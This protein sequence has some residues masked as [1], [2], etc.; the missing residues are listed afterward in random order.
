MRKLETKPVLRAIQDIFRDRPRKFHS[1]IE[2]SLRAAYGQ[3]HRKYHTMAHIDDLLKE[4]EKFAF[5]NKRAVLAAILFHDVFLDPGRYSPAFNGPSNE[6][7]SADIA[8]ST[9][10]EG[11]VDIVTTYRAKDLIL[12]TEKHEVP[13]G[14]TEAQLFIDMDMS[15]IGASHRRYAEY[16]AHNALECLTVF[17]PEQYLAGRMAFLT[18]AIERGNI[19]KSVHYAEREQQAGKNM[20]WELAHLPQLTATAAMVNHVAT[21]NPDYK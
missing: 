8:V 11:G 13:K 20:T 21:Y 2:E 15:I 4:A 12:M 14:D 9:L 17:T 5:E 7:V 1:D 6:K 3:K 18:K 16:A 10:A 19:F